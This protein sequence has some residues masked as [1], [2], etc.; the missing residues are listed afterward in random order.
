MKKSKTAKASPQKA[1]QSKEKRR[2]K[3]RAPETNHPERA[4]P[5]IPFTTA[6]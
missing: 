3:R 6:R 1:L 4:G 5:D 2:A